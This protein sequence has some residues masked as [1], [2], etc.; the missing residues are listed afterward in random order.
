MRALLEREFVLFENRTTIVRKR[1]FYFVTCNL[2]GKFQDF[3]F[4]L[5]MLQSVDV[6]KQCG[7][8]FNLGS[9]VKLISLLSNLINSFMLTYY[10]ICS[11]LLKVS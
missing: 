7:D 8:L 11:M 9:N 10:T 5:E 3:N 6:V 1:D 2:T 4:A